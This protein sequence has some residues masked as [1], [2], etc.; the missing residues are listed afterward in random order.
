[1]PKARK[2][3]DRKTEKLTTRYAAQQLERVSQAAEI[4]GRRRGEAVDESTFSRE[5]TLAAADRLIAESA[6]S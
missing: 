5:A 6:A 3:L 2:P 1:M 4:L